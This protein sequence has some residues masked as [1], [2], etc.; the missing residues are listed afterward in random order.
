MLKNLTRHLLLILA[1]ALAPCAVLAGS[2]PLVLGVQREAVEAW[3]VVRIMAD[4]DGRMSPQAALAAVVDW[5][6]EIGDFV[7]LDVTSGPIATERIGDLVETFL[8]FL[9]G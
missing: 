9:P 1:L 8:R 5:S 7:G 3:P 2:G 4:A 6:N